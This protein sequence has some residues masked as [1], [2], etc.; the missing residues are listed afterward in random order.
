VLSYAC[1]QRWGAD[2]KI[3]G[4]A[5]IVGNNSLTIIGVAPR[6]FLS[7][8]FGIGVDLVLNVGQESAQD[9]NNR[10]RR[11]LVPVGRLKPGV[12]IDQARAEVRALWSQLA[13]EYPKADKDR[14]ADIAPLTILSPDEMKSAR[15]ISAALIA[16]ALL[17]LLIACANTANL[18]L[19]LATLRRQEALI[20]TALGAS[21]GRLVREFLRETAVV[22]TLGGILGYSLAS[23][24]LAKLSRFDLDLPAFGLIPVSAD[25]HP[26]PLVAILT[27]ALVALASLAS[28]LAPALYASKPNLAAALT[29]EI[30]IGGTRRG[31]MRA[32]VVT[33]QVAVCTLVLAGTGLCWQSLHNLR[34][35]DPGFSARNI[36]A[37]LAFPGPGTPQPA[38][39]EWFDRIRRA[40]S[41]I[42]GVESVSLNEGLPLGD[43]SGYRDDVH[44]TDRPDNPLNKNVI[45]ANI[46]DETYFSTLGIRLLE[47]RVFRA[48]DIQTSLF[49]VVINH[50]MAAQYWPKQSAV[51][52]TIRIAGHDGRAGRD[53]VATVI[54]VVADGKYDDLNEAPQPFLYHPLNQDSLGVVNVTVRTSGD[55]R[56]W[57][58]PTMAALRKIGIALYLPP[59]TM[60]NWMNLTLFVPLVTLGCITGISILAMLLATAG[61]YGAISYS[62]SDRRRELGIRIALG[63]SPS[64]IMRMIFRQTLWIA[65]AGV[66]TGLA[67][68]I[69]AAIILAD[70][71]YQ[72]HPIEWTVLVPASLGMIAVCLLI[73]FAAARRWTRMNPMDAVRHV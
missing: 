73:A 57:L 21:R 61:L 1:W 68:S 40:A 69:A 37:V 38:G 72:V 58:Q 70:Q 14:T 16:C 12:S 30:A 62:V 56:Q 10:E 66:L 52:R 48:T 42:H 4:K 47:G 11:F 51:G 67:L 8:V 9:L 25:F 49:V 19:A 2:P 32:I 18:L 64:Q 53:G 39:P 28:G 6:E 5:V 3:V 24:A 45:E 26:G 36:A 43:G 41:E 34:N 20:K 27:V 7:P 17:I 35:V 23:F 54:G 59:T 63:A 44:F 15:L 33:V 13:T 29:G 50:Y 60:D 65:G 22:C 55:P 31:W 71:F 46:V